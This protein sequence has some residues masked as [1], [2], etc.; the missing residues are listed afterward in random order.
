MTFAAVADTH[1]L[2]WYIMGDA[3]LSVRAKNLIDDAASDGRQI[4]FSSISFVEIAYLIEKGRVPTTLFSLLAR[5][6]NDPLSVFVEIPVELRIARAMTRVPMAQIPDM[7]DRLI[8]ATALYLNVP[9]ISRDGK[10]TLSSVPT[11]W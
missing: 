11:I 6:R 8:A 3:R 5:A 10:I 7:P 9:L 4:A 2:H 1:V